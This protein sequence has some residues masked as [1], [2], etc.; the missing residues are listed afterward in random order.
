[1]QFFSRQC[2]SHVALSFVT[3]LHLAG[4]AFAIANLGVQA[5]AQD[6]N[7][8]SPPEIVDPIAALI[9]TAGEEAPPEP[10][11]TAAGEAREEDG[12]VIRGP[13]DVARDAA[14]A[15]PPALDVTPP[16]EEESAPVIGAPSDI[17][18]GAADIAAATHDKNIATP[19]MWRVTDADS[20]VWLFGTFHILPPD[21]N[22]RSD[23]LAAIMAEAEIYYFE[24]EGDAADAQSRTLKI[25]M[26]QGFNPPGETLTAML[27]EADAQKLE[28]ITIELGLPIAAIDP[29]R[30]WQAFLALSVQFIIDQ[31]FQPGAGADSVLI[32]EARGRSKELKFFETIEEQLGFFTGLPAEIEKNLLVLTIRDWEAQKAGFDELFTAWRTGNVDI[33]DQSMNDTMREQAPE[34]FKT[35]IVDRNKAWAQTIA[36]D[37]RSGSGKALVAV[38]A[39]HMA[40]GEYSLPALLR[41][42]GFD[43]VRYEY[44]KE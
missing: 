11:V 15:P 35:L 26:L 43:V 24:V 6:T 14:E 39:A 20:E 16:A 42:E 44:A 28:E 25:L 10:E 37:M 12:F 27:D 9:V 36:H 29:M 5:S 19:P 3:I 31:G 7:P 17:S 38:G 33:I 30:P 40:G 21:L 32:A 22:W 41:A 23:A 18:D 13:S 4:A 34:I 2:F 1:M 8:V